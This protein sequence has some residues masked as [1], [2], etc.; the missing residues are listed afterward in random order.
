MAASLVVFAQK[1][2]HRL[3]F[4][5]KK[6]YSLTALFALVLSAGSVSAAN[7]SVPFEFG[8]DS[9][10]QFDECT[11]LNVNNDDKTWK[12][13]SVYSSFNYQ[14]HS[15]NQ[16]DDWVIMPAVDFEAG[17]YE[18]SYSYR[19]QMND[20]ESFAIYIGD[21]PAAEAMAQEISRQ[22]EVK[23]SS[24]FTSVSIRF[25]IESAGEKYIG[26]YCFSPK[27]RYNLHVK[28]IKV[29]AV[30]NTLPAPAVL[31][32]DMEW[33]VAHCSVTLPAQN[34]A[35]GNLTETLG[36]EVTVDGEA[37][38]PAEALTGAP[39]ATLNFDIELESGI[40]TIAV[41]PSYT[42][43]GIV[44]YGELTE[45]AQLKAERYY[46]LPMPL[47]ASIAPDAQDADHALF[48]NVDNDQTEWEYYS[49]NYEDVNAGT[50]RYDYGNGNDA[51]D[52]LILPQMLTE[53]GGA[54]NLS[55]DLRT[56]TNNPNDLEIYWGSEATVAA[57]TNLVA[58][59]EAVDTGGEFAGQSLDFG[60]PA[61]TNI[62]IGVLC[63]SDR[64]RNYVSIKNIELDATVGLAPS[65]PLIKSYDF[66][67]KTGSITVT[68]PSVNISGEAVAGAMTLALVL[69]GE[70]F[71]SMP[72]S[73]GEDVVFDNV[74]LEFGS[75]VAKAVATVVID[76][77][78]YN[79][80]VAVRSFIVSPLYS[81]PFEYTPDQDTFSFLSIH[82]SNA[83]GRT[84][85]FYKDN[86]IPTLRCQY[87]SSLDMDD[88]AILP[89]VMIERAG[90]YRLTY[91]V[92]S[93]RNYPESIALTMGTGMQ[94][95]DQT[96][97]LDT[98]VDIPDSYTT[99]ETEF[100]IDE[101]G[102]YNIGIHG[103]SAPD[104]SYLY[105]SGLILERLVVPVYAVPEGLDGQLN[106][107]RDAITLTWS[108][109]AYEAVELKGYNV[110][111][112]D[113]KLNDIPLAETT[114][115]DDDIAAAGGTPVYHV[116]AVYADGEGER[117]SEASEK[118]T[119]MTT[120]IGAVS[121]ENALNVEC[122]K[123]LL[124]VSGVAGHRVHVVAI[125]GATVA[126]VKV[127]SDSIDIPLGAGVYV[128]LSDVYPA[129]KAVIR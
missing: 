90:T 6:F 12:Y 112:N 119:V 89:P 56:V 106:A 98:A 33:L 59:L 37:W 8:P 76:G 116:T 129:V 27:Y 14:Y 45:S 127:A 108:E 122:G 13:S 118:I 83:D 29:V 54:F 123:G 79:G 94:P 5:M 31:G 19:T 73:P 78:S 17:I 66:E 25:Q 9:Q 32:V 11:V 126:D 50:F 43:D 88:W 46:P 28:N 23:S 63:K 96:R 102:R 107:I 71:G 47:P 67:G 35:G 21:A 82:D 62:Y 53:A 18:L 58:Q 3:S 70:E 34:V 60:V 110:Y 22:E 38:T 91:T 95:S 68:A 81:V 36:L 42:L 69:D 97:V 77:E 51:N 16:A 61:G 115:T 109:P 117:E 101:P 92:R 111:R 1:Y 103:I 114:Y 87:N 113:V 20:A 128:V 2:Y 24:D 125:T 52:W 26:I 65:A 74:E 104:K 75:H 121:A 99:Y 10:E 40:H 100:V 15:T 85:T 30:D 105:F 49:P 55:F 124:R 41:R 84:W 39:G 57:M 72:C 80:Q 48:I 64:G 44:K 93:T 120:A 86:N 7:Y 4:N